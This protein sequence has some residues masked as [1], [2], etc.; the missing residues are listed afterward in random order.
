MIVIAAGSFV[1]GGSSGNEAP[2]HSVQVPS[3]A[4]AKTEITQGQWRAVMGNNPSHFSSCGDDCP[5]ESV[6]WDDAQAFVKKL[7]EQTGQRYRLPSEA[8]WEYACRAGGKHKYCGNDDV[9]AV[10][11]HI[12][13]SKV[14]VKKG[15]LFSKNEYGA[16][17]TYPVA[18]KRANA[19]GLY[20]MSGNVQEW[21]EDC[22]HDTYTDAPTDGS[23]WVSGS[24]QQRVLRGGSWIGLSEDARAAFRN[25]SSTTWRHVSSGFR[26]VVR[27]A[28]TF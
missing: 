3:F 24:C 20:D 8:E 16:N 6:S 10:A 23:A 25:W 2:A 17:K 22:Y 21:V 15:G 9:D 11:W 28:R 18:K 7:S 19:W 14:L 4:M 1:M 27:S 26:V 5:V 13:N 12:G